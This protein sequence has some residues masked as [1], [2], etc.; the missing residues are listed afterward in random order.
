[1]AAVLRLAPAVAAVVLGAALIGRLAGW[2]P[3]GAVAALL[4]AAALLAVVFA[5][6]QRSA[7][8]ADQRAAQVDTDAALGGELRSAHWFATSGERDDWAEYHLNRAADRA[9][10]VSW[11][12]LYPAP[13]SRRPWAI[14]ALLSAAA[15]A[16]A[17][18]A[19]SARAPRPSDAIAGQIAALGDALPPEIQAKLN[20]L[21]AGMDEGAITGEA[22]EASLEE[23]KKLLD[24][25]DPAMREKL[26]ELAK[27]QPLGADAT[28]K[29]KDLDEEDL[30]ERAENSAAGMPEDVRWA[31]EDLAARLANSNANRDTAEQNQS[32]STE[33]GEKARGSAEAEAGQANAAEAGMQMMRQAASAAEAAESQMMMAGGGAQGGDSSS[34]PGGNS[35]NPGGKVDFKS[36][37][38]A[39]RQEIIEASQDVLGENVPKEDI[40]RKTERGTSTLGFQRTTPVAAY[41]RSRATA[42]PTVPDARRPLVFHYFLRQ[43]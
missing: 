21:M 25:M 41:D 39:L 37:A 30:A 18:I 3:L 4:G 29:R 24:A 35:P 28:T 2:P 5:V 40:R 42:P 8:S 15:L 11:D 27:N 26:A 16:V 23:L 32:A 38:Q 31:L 1:M 19:P 12:S 43:R 17:F 14:A 20:Q 22:A 33:T 9:S 13:A 7:V 36:I 6:T 10:S 34:G